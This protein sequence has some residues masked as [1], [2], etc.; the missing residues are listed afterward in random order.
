MKPPTACHFIENKA[1]FFPPPVE[2]GDEPHPLSTPCWCL[3]THEATGPDG[4][5]VD[6]DICV[7]GR[8]CYEPEV[9]LEDI[10][11]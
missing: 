9:D 8:S 2:A 4:D 3:R 5:A 6:V 7:K 1:F 11:A 10:S